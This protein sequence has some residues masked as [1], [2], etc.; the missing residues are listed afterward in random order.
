VEY[1]TGID[2]TNGSGRVFDM[3]NRMTQWCFFGKVGVCMPFVA[4]NNFFSLASSGKKIIFSNEGI[5]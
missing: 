4:K 5:P 1:C 2:A 3:V